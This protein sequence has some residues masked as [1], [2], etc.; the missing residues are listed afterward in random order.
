MAKK[1]MKSG[2]RLQGR[3]AVVEFESG[4][5]AI[6]DWR[7]RLLSQAL[8]TCR[9]TKG[10]TMPP[11]DGSMLLTGRLVGATKFACSLPNALNLLHREEARQFDVMNGTGGYGDAG[12]G[13]CH[14]GVSHFENHHHAGAIG[15]PPVHRDKLAPG[16]CKHFFNRRLAVAVGVFPHR[17]KGLRCIICRQTEQHGPPPSKFCCG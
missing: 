17:V 13:R 7:R 12:H 15:S 14:S 6:D 1:G 2:S 9:K 16:G 11:L 5:V 3:T 8:T 10:G 4:P